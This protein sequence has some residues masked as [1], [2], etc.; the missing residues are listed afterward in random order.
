M[1]LSS[2]T[3]GFYRGIRNIATQDELPFLKD[4]IEDT[5]FAKLK[6]FRR[7]F[8][9][10]VESVKVEMNIPSNQLLEKHVMRVIYKK[11]REKLEE[12]NTTDNVI[13][14]LQEVYRKNSI[15]YTLKLERI[16]DAK[17]LEDAQLDEYFKKTKKRERL[18]GNTTTDKI[19]YCLYSTK[20]SLNEIVLAVLIYQKI[21]TLTCLEIL[22]LSSDTYST[23]L[24][25]DIFD[26]FL[27]LERKVKKE[28]SSSV[29]CISQM[30]IFTSK[31]WLACLQLQS[32]Y[33]PLGDTKRIFTI[34]D[35]N[36]QFLPEIEP[37]KLDILE[38]GILM[39][40]KDNTWQKALTKREEDMKVV[41]KLSE[42]EEN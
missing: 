12:N 26:P 5:Q 23:P 3:R 6:D 11:A 36:R 9:L 18:D 40:K 4:E 39:C 38:C 28:H 35:T 37:Y 20:K 10:T 29:D 34:S 14:E 7:I 16:E 2:V 17:K 31:E 32:T 41:E 8:A 21:Q 33:L 22:S 15:M 24:H 25:K 30:L 19:Y 13:K 42:I 27:T 1:A